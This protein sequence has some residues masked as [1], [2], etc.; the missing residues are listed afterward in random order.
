MAP[1]PSL[2]S[3]TF[4]TV[5]DVLL[6]VDV[7]TSLLRRW[8]TSFSITEEIHSQDAG[9]CQRRLIRVYCRAHVHDCFARTHIRRQQRS[10]RLCTKHFTPSRI[11][12][13]PT[14][15][16][17]HACLAAAAPSM[18][19]GCEASVRCVMAAETEMTRP[20]SGLKARHAC[21]QMKVHKQRAVPI[22]K[23]V[24]SSDVQ[25]SRVGRSSSMHR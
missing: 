21:V 3:P 17:W 10:R 6:F 2:L 19:A 14:Y 13:Q 8:T 20:L 24:G 4:P 23:R 22:A 5:R 16:R 7:Y 11:S 9:V 25:D 15:R 12:I 1:S 18:R